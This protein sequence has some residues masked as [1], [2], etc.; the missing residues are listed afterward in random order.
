M[1]TLSQPPSSR[2]LGLLPLEWLLQPERAPETCELPPAGL[3]GFTPLPWWAAAA[4]SGP[5]R[6]EVLALRRDPRPPRLMVLLPGLLQQLE[7]LRSGLL[8]PIPSWKKQTTN[9]LPALLARQLSLR[10]HWPMEVRCLIRSRPVLGQHRL[11]R[12]IR[13]DNQRGS[14][15]APLPHPQP[16]HRVWLVDD[17][18]TTGATACAAAEAFTSQGWRVSGLICL[19]RTPAGRRGQTVI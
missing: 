1:A 7:P 10:L 14:F 4:Y 12:E 15:T 6:Q 2:L 18:L 11:G 17:I 16:G 5:I 9:P 3:H 8:V 19:A 13:W